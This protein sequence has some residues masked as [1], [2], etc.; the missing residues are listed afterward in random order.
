MRLAVGESTA[1]P[2]GGWAANIY[3]YLSTLGDDRRIFDKVGT[4]LPFTC[5]QA[6]VRVWMHVRVGVR[7]SAFVRV[8]VCVS[9][10]VRVRRL[11]VCCS[12]SI[13]QVADSTLCRRLCCVTS[14]P[15]S[16]SQD[17]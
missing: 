2:M 14:R 5:E 15:R 10:H 13:Y 1:M 12:D 11:G 16:T 8:G 17:E 6:S 7:V 9:M 3:G 4:S